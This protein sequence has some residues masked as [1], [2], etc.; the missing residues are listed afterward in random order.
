MLDAFRVDLALGRGFYGGADEVAG[1]VLRIYQAPGKGGGVPAVESG[2]RW[3]RPYDDVT[4]W[5]P[6]V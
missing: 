2:L 6:K 3:Y 4:G 5:D 1:D